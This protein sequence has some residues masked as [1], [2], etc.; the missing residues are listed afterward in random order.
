M[1]YHETIPKFS[2]FQLRTKNVRKTKAPEW[3]EQFCFPGNYPSLCQ[4]INI[5]VV[6]TDIMSS[7]CYAMAEIHL[8]EICDDGYDLC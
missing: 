8:D 3:N 2:K 1:E 5:Q 7:G 6:A 4:T